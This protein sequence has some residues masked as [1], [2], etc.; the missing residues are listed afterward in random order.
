[1]RLFVDKIHII[2]HQPSNFEHN[3]VVLVSAEIVAVPLTAVVV[4]S[5]MVVAEFEAVAVV[6]VQVAANVAVVAVATVLALAVV[7]KPDNETSA[8]QMAIEAAIHFA[9]A[10][11]LANMK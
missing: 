10:L 5:V 3:S 1:M 8:T 6:V 11:G 7:A 2:E 4:E 9:D